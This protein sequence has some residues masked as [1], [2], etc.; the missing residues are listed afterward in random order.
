MNNVA[1]NN[2]PHHAPTLALKA[3]Y[4]VIHAGKLSFIPRKPVCNTV[5]FLS[6]LKAKANHC[7]QVCQSA[8][9][10]RFDTTKV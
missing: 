7:V 4:A 2:A 3:V 9:P 1:D 8:S 10:R 5:L 6:F